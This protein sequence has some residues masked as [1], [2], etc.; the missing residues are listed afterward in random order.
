MRKKVG[1]VTVEE[2]NEI[3]TLFE[4]QNG[5]SELAKIVT[6]DNKELYER[7]IADLGQTSVK[8]QNWWSRTSKKYN[9]ESLEGCNWEIDFDTCEI[10][11]V[12][13]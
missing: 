5:L 8:F 1:Q 12:G 2:K 6:V 11:L 7:L 4:R 10:F 3:L 13:N 9:W